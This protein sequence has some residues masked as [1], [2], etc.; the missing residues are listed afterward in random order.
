M[1]NFWGNFCQSL[2]IRI[3]KKKIFAYKGSIPLGEHLTRT[4]QIRCAQMEWAVEQRQMLVE[5]VLGPIRSEQCVDENVVIVEWSSV[6][7]NRLFGTN[8]TRYSTQ[9]INRVR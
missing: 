3:Y 2:L 8:F 5:K 4:C 6:Q 7:R 1:H 9:R